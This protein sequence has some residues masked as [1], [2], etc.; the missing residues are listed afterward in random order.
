MQKFCKESIQ[1]DRVNKERKEKSFGKG[2]KVRKKSQARSLYISYKN[3]AKL[4][5]MQIRERKS[6]VMPTR[7]GGK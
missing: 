2:P 4:F 7:K 1:K 3:K 6:T 5:P